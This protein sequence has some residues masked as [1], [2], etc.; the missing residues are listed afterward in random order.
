MRIITL[1]F[2]LFIIAS[3]CA[4]EE[5]AYFDWKGLKSYAAKNYTESLIYFDKAIEQDPNYLDAWVHKGDA[6]RAQ[7]DYNASL[8]SYGGALRRKNDSTAGLVGT[9]RGICS[10]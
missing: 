6:Q 9:D 7:K 10:P 5:T 3:V 1:S 8:E 4:A 2:C